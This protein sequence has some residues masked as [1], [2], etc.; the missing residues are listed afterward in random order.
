M[1]GDMPLTRDT[2]P[3]RII[4]VAEGENPHVQAQARGHVF[5]WFVAQLFGAF[6]CKSP[7]KSS[8]NVRKN[9]YEVDITTRFELSGESAIAEC[10]A[11][12]SYVPVSELN[13]F[14]GKLTTERFEDPYTH[15]W[16]VAIPGLTAD[17]NQQARK[18][19][20]NDARFRL[21]TATR[22]YELVQQK[23]WFRAIESTDGAVLS[24]HAILVSAGRVCALAKQLDPTTGLPAQVLVQRSNGVVTESELQLLAAHDYA[25]GLQIRD[26]GS[27]GAACPR[28]LTSPGALIHIAV[29]QLAVIGN[30]SHATIT[31]LDR[32]EAN[33]AIAHTK[34][35]TLSDT[36]AAIAQDVK[37]L[38]E[39]LEN[40]SSASDRELREIAAFFGI[41]D[42]AD[43]VRRRR[44]IEATAQEYGMLKEQVVQYERAEH[45]LSRIAFTDHLTGVP[46]RAYFFR[47][48]LERKNSLGSEP[49]TQHII[50][51]DIDNFHRINNSMGH[52]TGDF[53][54]AETARRLM[55]VAQIHGAEFCRYGGDEFLLAF[56]SSKAQL[57]RVQ[58]I[59][60]E[61]L[62]IARPQMEYGRHKIA[63]TLSAGIAALS[64][65]EPIE[66]AINMADQ[67]V[68]TAK[69][70]GC[71]RVETFERS[72]QRTERDRTFANALETA[73]ATDQ[74]YLVYQP[75]FA[76]DSQQLCG[77]EALVRWQHPELGLMWPEQFLLSAEARRLIVPIGSWA[78][79]SACMAA[80]AWI[81]PISVYVNVSPTQLSDPEFIDVLLL[82]LTQSGLAPSRLTLEVTEM[83]FAVEDQ[84]LISSTVKK[85]L[86]L[87][88]HLCLDEFG[89]GYSSLAY[90]TRIRFSSIKIDRVFVAD[91]SSEAREAISAVRAATAIG[92]SLGIEVV[93][94]GVESEKQV[95]LARELG[96]TQLQGYILGMPMSAQDAASLTASLVP[97]V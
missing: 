78:L 34:L 58:A 17:G 63:L 12:K 48:L 4:I 70:M 54:L 88:V 14:Y 15:G 31:L 33:T 86:D 83:A 20:S 93:A 5:E 60:D 69:E 44:E 67:A 16:F 80:A 23:G 36:S 37:W 56:L 96:C 39:R 1:T 21:V 77:F 26:C 64:S 7:I 11:Y 94:V 73:I 8:L 6:G 19:E 45:E 27:A 91:L 18:I 51:V 74:L 3:P 49:Y 30:T 50:F 84:T 81:S 13:N 92:Q 2:S 43:P 42:I 25:K 35:N 68:R 41:K 90:I 46:N 59:A 87:G 55:R 22:I 38:V 82:A 61:L 65:V 89:V 10:K 9:G 57:E 95:E 53:V 85:I 79:R 76:A 72:I 71:D 32:I 75:I 28:A 24:D 47:A 97:M 40:L 62:A 29:E 66:Q 52:D